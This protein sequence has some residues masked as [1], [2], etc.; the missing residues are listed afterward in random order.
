MRVFRDLSDQ[1]ITTP[2][3]LTFG[4]FDGLHLGHQ[5]IF[6]RVVERAAEIG[7]AATAVTFEPHPR[8]FLHPESAPLPL[9]T[10][11]QKVEGM[12]RLGIEQVLV[13]SFNDELARTS[14]E[15]FLLDIIFGRLDA[16]GVYLGHGFAFGHQ[17]E[18]RFELLERIATRLGRS[19]GEVPEV[20]IRGQRV[21]STAIRRLLSY[22]RVNLARRMLGRPYSVDSRVVRGRMIGREKLSYATA[23]MQP[24]NCVIPLEGVYVTLTQV[25]DSWRRSVTNV[26]YRP[27]IGKDSQLTVETHLME[28]DRELYGKRVR[29]RFLHRLRP[30]MKFESV[31]A[32][33]LQIDRDYRRAARYFERGE[34]RRNLEF[35]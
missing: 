30:E 11:E 12:E 25:D 18:G 4:V 2:T 14:A 3:V 8:A 1:G 20:T 32:L 7:I 10:L 35:M 17:R 33:R 19:A 26:G 6:R 15:R 9:Q 28:F 34:V 5:L 29:V 23:N 24:H 27:T 31:D 16:L 22:G 13:L 21:S